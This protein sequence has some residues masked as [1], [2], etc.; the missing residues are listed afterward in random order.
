MQ[1]RDGFI[2]PGGFYV[3]ITRVRNGQGLF[4]RDFDK[5]YVKVAD[6][7]NNKIA[8]EQQTSQDVE[9][10]KKGLMPKGVK[11]DTVVIMGQEI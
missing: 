8:E 6:E 4:L 5:S 9:N 10:H 11:M 2:V 3:A 1:F 7:L